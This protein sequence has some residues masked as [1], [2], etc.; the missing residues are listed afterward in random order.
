L[1]GPMGFILIV[2]ICAALFMFVV[3]ALLGRDA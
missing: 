2:V 1:R 3:V